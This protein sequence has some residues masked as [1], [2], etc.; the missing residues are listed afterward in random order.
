M[1]SSRR[2]NPRP[3]TR[4]STPTAGT[5]P[6]S[7]SRISSTEKR[8]SS[9]STTVAS[10]TQSTA[11]RHDCWFLTCT[12]GSQPSGSAVSNFASTTKPASGRAS[13]TTNT[14]TLGWN[15]DTPATNGTTRHKQPG[16][17]PGEPDS[18]TDAT[19]VDDTEDLPMTTPNPAAAE[20]IDTRT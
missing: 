15:S 10:W 9:S 14:A 11:V 20:V 6:T 3:S 12:C 5:P 8:G 13:A 18:R 4:W 2:S 19:S 17:A 16:R 7:R 1:L